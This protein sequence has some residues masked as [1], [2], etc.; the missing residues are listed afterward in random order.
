M[1]QKNY[2]NGIEKLSLETLFAQLQKLV[3]HLLKNPLVQF[4]QF[5]QASNQSIQRLEE[6]FFKLFF[7]K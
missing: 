2:H 5:S 4:F 7:F 3:L 1:K 6:C